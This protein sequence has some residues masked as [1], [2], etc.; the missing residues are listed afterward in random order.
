MPLLKTARDV[1]MIF[2][3]AMD[4]YEEVR[5][6]TLFALKT[7]YVIYLVVTRMLE[8]SIFVQEWL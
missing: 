8:I 6:E 5:L 2:A 4:P 3:A 7:K 1:H